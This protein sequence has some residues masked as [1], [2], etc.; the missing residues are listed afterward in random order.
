[1]QFQKRTC[2]IGVDR[3]AAQTPPRSSAV[4]VSEWVFSI[5]G[6][7]VT[8]LMSW[9]KGDNHV[10]LSPFGG[11]IHRSHNVIWLLNITFCHTVSQKLQMIASATAA[12]EWR[13]RLI[14]SAHFSRQLV[15][16]LRNSPQNRCTLST[17]AIIY[18]SA[19]DANIWPCTHSWREFKVMSWV[20][21]KAPVA[22]ASPLWW[23]P[24][25]SP[26]PSVPDLCRWNNLPWS[27]FLLQKQEV[28]SIIA[29]T[30]EHA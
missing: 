28:H 22:P 15:H 6:N 5:P 1:M 7:F 8:F 12:G 16:L 23:V 4:G 21:H 27:N 13:S 10:W 18:I 24:L 3:K 25:T 29:T 14:L 11:N 9:L 20:G 19:I 17:F 26:E 2:F 30:V